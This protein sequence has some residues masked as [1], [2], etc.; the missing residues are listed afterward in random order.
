MQVGIIYI[1]PCVPDDELMTAK[2]R[3]ST[4]NNVKRL[5]F[6]SEIKTLNYYVIICYCFI[7]ALILLFYF[8]HMSITTNKL[9]NIINRLLN[10]ISYDGIY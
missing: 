1:R 8:V 4:I 5:C 2:S 3:F 9:Y 10:L 6:V 7:Y